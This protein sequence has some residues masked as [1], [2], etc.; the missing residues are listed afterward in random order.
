MSDTYRAVVLTRQGGPEVLEVEQFPIEEPG[1]KQ[2]RV[3]IRAAGVGATDLAML[4]GKGLESSLYGMKALDVTSYLLAI[5]GVVVVA[6]F[7]SAV[8]AGR[9]AR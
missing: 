7:A 6:L 2:L 1:P 3:R 5:A 9:A 4:A 8:P